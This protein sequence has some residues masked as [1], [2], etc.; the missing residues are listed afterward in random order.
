PR[1]DI[2]D[3]DGFLGDILLVNGT[4]YPY[5]EVLPRRYRFRL[6][7]VSVA[8]FIKLALGVNKSAR[9]SQ[10]T[11]VPFYFIANDGNLVVSPIALTELDEQGVAERY[12]IVVDFSAFAPGDSIYLVNLLQQTDGRRPDGAVSID[13]ALKAG[14]DDPC[15]GPFL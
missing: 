13:R 14:G 2:F 7:N 11:K 1:F 3:T 5:F 15:V 9:F 12:D 6:L 8:R 10:A 4:Y